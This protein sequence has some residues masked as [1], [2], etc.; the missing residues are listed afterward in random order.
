[1]RRET[2][3]TNNTD[4]N[5]KEQTIEKLKNI[6]ENILGILVLIASVFMF[7][8]LLTMPVESTEAKLQRQTI[9]ATVQDKFSEIDA[10]GIIAFTDTKYDITVSM[11]NDPNL[12]DV[13]VTK[14]QYH[15]IGKGSHVKGTVVYN[16]NKKLDSIELA[17]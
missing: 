3:K 17:D 16:K 9:N 12:H 5:K 6:R 8:L 2:I 13:E 14:E 1:M 15:N 4:Y 10:S 7:Q 11:E